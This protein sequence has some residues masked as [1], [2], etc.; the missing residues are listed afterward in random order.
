MYPNPSDHPFHLRLP[1][2]PNDW[3]REQGLHHIPGYKYPHTLSFIDAFNPAKENE[4]IE[5]FTAIRGRDPEPPR[6]IVIPPV[7]S[8]S[9]SPGASMTKEMDEPAGGWGQYVVDL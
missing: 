3:Y 1:A 5:A 6:R 8:F 7:A 4:I 9:S 2:S